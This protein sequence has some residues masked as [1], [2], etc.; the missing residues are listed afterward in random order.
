MAHH[1]HQVKKATASKQTAAVK[2]AAKASTAKQQEEQAAALEE[3]QRMIAKE[4][5]LIAEHRAFQGDMA[6]NDWLNAEAEV[7]ARLA[8]RH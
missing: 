8:A 1:K 2:A 7:D 5:Y 4:A 3:R 6:L